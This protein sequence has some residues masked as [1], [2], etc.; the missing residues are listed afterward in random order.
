MQDNHKPNHKCLA[1]GKEY[2]ACDSCDKKISKTWRAACCTEP[3]YKAYYAM[4]Q[5]GQGQI[6]REEARDVLLEQDAL[7]W[8]KA[9]GKA[10][11]EE[12]IGQIEL[13]EEITGKNESPEETP[14][15]ETVGE[16]E[17]EAP[18]AQEESDEITAPKT[19]GSQR[20]NKKRR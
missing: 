19:E 13:L 10:L 6:S 1:C 15:E 16:P 3:H 9:P 5:Y 14:V 18:K 20:K 7:S 8:E 11:I 2:Y 12:I 17:P 4:W